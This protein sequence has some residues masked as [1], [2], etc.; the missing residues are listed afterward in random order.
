MSK[1]V[2]DYALIHLTKDWRCIGVE[3]CVSVCAQEKNWY[4][5]TLTHLWRDACRERPKPRDISFP[6]FSDANVDWPPQAAARKLSFSARNNEEEIGYFSK[7]ELAREGQALGSSWKLSGSCVGFI[8]AGSRKSRSWRS[9]GC[10]KSRFGSRS[11][12]DTPER[13][14]H[15]K[16]TMTK[17][18]RRARQ[19]FRTGES[20]SLSVLDA[21]IASQHEGKSFSP[22]VHPSARP[23]VMLVKIC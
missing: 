8:S 1:N 22:S 13:D 18:T 20:N 19:S 21:S 23:L 12:E 11:S 6:I 3:N 15:G 7:T 16:D 10:P 9:C 17:T 5:V 4:T 2:R 14:V